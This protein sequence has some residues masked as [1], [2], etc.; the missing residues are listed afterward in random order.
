MM[1]MVTARSAFDEALNYKCLE[2]PNA[3]NGLK[4]LKLGSCLWLWTN[5]KKFPNEVFS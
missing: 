3:V 4:S 1:D 5:G 2:V